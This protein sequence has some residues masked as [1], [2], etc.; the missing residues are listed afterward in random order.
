MVCVRQRK[1][2]N[3]QIHPP[4]QETT[5]LGVEDCVTSDANSGSDAST[6]FA[7]FRSRV[8]THRSFGVGE[9]MCL[10]VGL[11]VLLYGLWGHFIIEKL[12]TFAITEIFKTRLGRLP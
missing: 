9:A 10:P 12:L 4:T 11:N 6:S 1:D 8:D 5:V 3:M 7:G 2:R